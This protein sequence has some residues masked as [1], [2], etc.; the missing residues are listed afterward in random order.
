MP[1]CRGKPALVAI[2]VFALRSLSGQTPLRGQVV[3]ESGAPIAGAAV[4]RIMDYDQFVTTQIAAASTL[5]SDAAGVFTMPRPLDNEWPSGLSVSAPGRGTMVVDAAYL[6]LAPIVLPRM[7]RLAG[8]VRDADG[9]PVAGARILVRDWLTYCSFARGTGGER[10]F[11]L[12]EGCVAL[13]SGADG[14]FVVDGAHDTA[15]YVEVASAGY[16]TQQH[17]PLDSSQP[18]DFVLRAPATITFEVHDAEGR[19]VAGAEVEVHRTGPDYPRS[20]VEGITG[21]D[22]TCRL[23]RLPGAF[24]V[25]ARDPRSGGNMGRH[26]DRFGD[27]EVLVL[28]TARAAAAA[29]KPEAPPADAVTLRGRFVDPTRRTPVGGGTVWLVPGA[30]HSPG[31]HLRWVDSGYGPAKFTAATDADGRFT[32][33]APPG[34]YWL[35]GAENARGEHFH[36]IGTARN[37]APR[38]LEVVAGAEP[39]ELVVEL[40]PR[41]ELAG[42]VDVAG[43]P[44]P[45]FLRF[46]PDNLWINSNWSDIAVLP[47]T[48]I[49]ARGRFTATE[50]QQATYVVQ[51]L[52]PRLPRQGWPDKVEVAR[53]DLAP[54]TELKLELAA[55]RP[56]MVRGRVVGDL[57]L[58]RLAV[59]SLAANDDRRELRG[60]P[61]YQGPFVPLERDGSF[62][63][64]EPPGPRCL[65]VVDLRTGVMLHRDA[66]R[67]VAPGSAHES[68][69]EPEVHRC[70]LR[71]DSD[72]PL[73]TMEL[74]IRVDPKRGPAGF[75]QMDRALRPYVTHIAPNHD[76]LLLLLPPGL[77]RLEVIQHPRYQ[78]E[79]VVA[80]GEVE[81]TAGGKSTTKL[82]MR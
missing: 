82:S 44:P 32:M 2:L 20:E 23:P 1:Q 51:L 11:G 3:D 17:G 63:L 21:L 53:V 27:H 73:E 33:N 34:R 61:S 56:A 79:R 15:L 26:V 64:R 42:R 52:L 16:L 28:A 38:P 4:A 78:T 76:G 24:W 41:F 9:R 39:A 57:P 62:V 59:V 80:R 6:G 66:V 12:A 43:L 58:P 67:D 81:A 74:A 25:Q 37:P 7:R 69:L 65:M 29:A 46:V 35:G 10:S 18:F 48:A 55:S 50:L 5:R 22:G 49:D 71:F 70:E 30:E 36:W 54:G 45:C 60:W 68:E 19:P 77:A 40:Q 14:R 31:E 72:D 8:R 13:L 47:R 75:G